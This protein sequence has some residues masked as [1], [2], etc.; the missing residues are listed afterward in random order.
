MFL[1]G[2]FLATLFYFKMN[3]SYENG[4]FA[5]IKADID[6]QITPKDTPDSVAVKAMNVCYHLMSNKGSIF[7][8]SDL[9]PQADLFHSVTVDLETTRGACGSYSEVLARILQTYHL[10]VRIAQMESNGVYAAHNVVET[11]VRQRWVVLDPTFNLCFVRPDGALAD[12]ADVSKDWGYYSRQI[13]PG[14]NPAYRYEGVRYFNWTKIPVVLPALKS[15]LNKVI[16]PERT[17]AISL[18][19]MFLNTFS[20]C[21]YVLLALYFPLLL[22]TI[23]RLAAHSSSYF[24]SSHFPPSRSRP[25]HSRPSHSQSSHSQSSHSQSSRGLPS[26]VSSLISNS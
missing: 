21:L 4:L 1:N 14:Y 3:S 16:G 6:A 17:N 15:L 10:P 25:S 9:G 8:N 22:I 18:R 20:V 23:R 7:Y 24:R 2:F 12:F 19:T 13:P 11:M 26:G 5:S